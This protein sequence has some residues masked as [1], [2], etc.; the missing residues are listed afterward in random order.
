MSIHPERVDP[1]SVYVLFYFRGQ[2]F[3]GRALVT[4]V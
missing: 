1:A 3:G 2:A 4:L